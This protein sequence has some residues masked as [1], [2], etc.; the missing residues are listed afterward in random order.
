MRRRL[1]VLLGAIGLALATATPGSAAPLDFL[2]ALSGDY[3]RID[4]REVGR[5]FHIYVRLPQDYG[6]T[7]GR[8]YP[9][10]YLLDGDSAFPLLAT[11]HLFLGYDD[12]LPEAIIV[13]IAYGSFD[14]AVNRREVDFTGPAAGI[15]PQEA[16]APAFQAFLEQELLPRVEARYRAD[17]KRRILVGQSRGGSFVLFSAFT[18]P[19]LFWGRIASNPSFYRDGAR[20]FEPPA[21]GARTDLQLIVASGSRDRPELRAGAL[22][23]FK[24]WQGRAGTPWTLTALTV[25]GGTHAADIANVYRLGMRR[26]FPAPAA[27]R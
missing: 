23:W 13:G 7:G 5:P 4:S 24:A 21:R 26:L 1:R 20:L 19:D 3:F 22:K 25:E 9:I 6:T 12:G 14:P 15:P 2:P 27:A 17:P 16:G 8:L 11:E 10:V 18:R